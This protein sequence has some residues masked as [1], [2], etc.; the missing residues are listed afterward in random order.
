MLTSSDLT[1][2]IPLLQTFYFQ[3]ST[4]MPHSLSSGFQ[5]LGFFARLW[6]PC[7]STVSNWST[8]CLLPQGLCWRAWPTTGFHSA[9][10]SQVPPSRF[11]QFEYATPELCLMCR[12]VSRLLRIAS[13]AGL[14]TTLDLIFLFL[15]FD[16]LSS[17]CLFAC[18]SLCLSRLSAVTF[19]SFDCFPV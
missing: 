10:T 8:P 19:L 14:P 11:L 4:N 5:I 9:Q 7:S 6:Y 17:V 1:P 2:G 12:S 18:L 13:F 16:L 15:I 3:G